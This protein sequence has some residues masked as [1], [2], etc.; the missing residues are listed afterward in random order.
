VMGMTVPLLYLQNQYTA[1]HAACF[2][3]KYVDIAE[4]LIRR[5]ADVNVRYTMRLENASVSVVQRSSDYTSLSNNLYCCRVRRS[6][7]RRRWS[8]L[9]RP[10]GFVC[11]Y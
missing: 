5:G 10:T 11:R 1:L 8:C 3:G 9:M 7:M 6:P 2:G 4:T